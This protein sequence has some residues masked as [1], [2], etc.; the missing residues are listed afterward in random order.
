MPKTE[1]LYLITDG[2]R[3]RFI[4]RSPSTGHFATVEEIDGGE[5]LRILRQELRSSL[6]ARSFSSASPRR[7]AV[8]KEDYLRPAKEAFAAEVA[9]R[10]VALAEREQLGGIFLAAPARLLGPL[11]LRLDRRVPVVGA[12]RKDLTKAP[13]HE[14]GAWL[15]DALKRPLLSV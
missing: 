7:S 5:R 14:L 4:R 12:I 6:P 15:N 10:A 1:I 13:D 9:D 3:A 2:G 8:G 11:R